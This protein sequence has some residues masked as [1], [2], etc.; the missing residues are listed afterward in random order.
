ME[1]GINHARKTVDVCALLSLH[2]SF[3]SCSS[4]NEGL[5]YDG[6]SSSS[7]SLLSGQVYNFDKLQEKKNW[8]MAQLFCQELGAQLLS[9]GS[10]EE[11]HFVANALNKFFG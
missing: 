6:T 2:W 7:F 4:P 8:I 3:G 9:L 10:Y 11:E 5:A 1:A